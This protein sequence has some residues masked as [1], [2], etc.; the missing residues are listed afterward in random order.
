MLW[1]LTTCAMRSHH[2]H[3]KQQLANSR[4]TSRWHTRRWKRQV[5]QAPTLEDIR[6]YMCFGG[7]TLQSELG[8]I[9]FC[10]KTWCRSSFEE[11]MLDI[12]YVS[13]FCGIVITLYCVCLKSLIF[14]CCSFH[15]WNFNCSTN[16][17]V[18]G[19]TKA[20]RQLPV[21]FSYSVLFISTIHIHRSLSEIGQ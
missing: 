12:C 5:I 6:G 9:S 10:K 15:T 16:F 21:R 19:N 7:N 17:D 13:H 4:E 18:A 2:H 1:W 8:I 14:K 3:G 20:R 11:L